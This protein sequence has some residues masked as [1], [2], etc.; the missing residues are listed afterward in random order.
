MSAEDQHIR[1]I[2]LKQKGSYNDNFV[3]TGGTC[4]G[5]DVAVSGASRDYCKMIIVITCHLWLTEATEIYGCL[6]SFAEGENSIVLWM[7]MLPSRILSK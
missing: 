4:F 1:H 5:R 6:C 2:T 3:I 7:L